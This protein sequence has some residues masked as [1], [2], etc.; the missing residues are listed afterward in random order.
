MAYD[1]PGEEGS[2]YKTLEH[3][4][5]DMVGRPGEL[6]LLDRGCEALVYVAELDQILLVSCLGATGSREVR[7][8]NLRQ[9]VR[10]IVEESRR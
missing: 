9:K 4:I 3:M 2:E 10:Q 8:E 5:D 1:R 6:F 7:E